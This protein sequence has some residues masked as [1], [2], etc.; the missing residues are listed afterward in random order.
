M[1]LDEWKKL[2]GERQKP[3]YNLRKAGEGEDLTQWKNMRELQKE[4]EPEF[5]KNGRANEKNNEVD[6][7]GAILFGTTTIDA[8]LLIASVFRKMPGMKIPN[9]LRARNISTSAFVS[10][11]RR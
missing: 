6:K 10:R 1:T 5:L 3:Q 7:V 2:Q 8:P 4:K 11:S 9:V